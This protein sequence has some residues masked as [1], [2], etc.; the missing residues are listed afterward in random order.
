MSGCQFKRPE[1]SPKSV[2]HINLRIFEIFDQLEVICGRTFGQNFLFDTCGL[3]IIK[4]IF[5][6][7]EVV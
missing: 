1:N 5:I 6:V 4:T 7:S 2:W 3:S